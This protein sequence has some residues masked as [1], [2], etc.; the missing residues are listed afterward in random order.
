MRAVL[1]G[2][3]AFS[4]RCFATLRDLPEIELVGVVTRPPHGA[5]AGDFAA[6]GDDARADGIPTLEVERNA[7]AEIADF[8]RVR[9]ADIGFC[10]GWHFL[11]GRD[12]LDAAP[13][14]VVGYHPAE[15]PKNRGRHPI[16]WALALG[17][18]RTGSTFFWLD[19]AADAGDIIDQR[20]VPITDADD[21]G[22][23][24][25]KLAD[26]AQDQLASIGPTIANG[27]A[28]RR[29]QAAKGSTIWRKRSAEDG[30]IDWRMPARGIR[31]L[32]RALARPYPGAHVTT[33]A[34]D[35]KVWRAELGET[36]P[37]NLEPGRVVA[38]AADG[39][40]IQTGEGTLWLREHEFAALP[41]VGSCL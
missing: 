24:Y 32:V 10:L 31:D 29:R 11:L 28:P 20:I 19:A 39:V 18:E 33:R 26:V 17:L 27:T 37:R 7:Q 35:V 12:V 34:G 16:I 1:I 25:A 41:E 15:L 9:R 23:L 22:S 3:V 21:A 4:R 36:A 8:I 6:L 5:A 14:G 40:C 30:R 13:G 2:C 38:A